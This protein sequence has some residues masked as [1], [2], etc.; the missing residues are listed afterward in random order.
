MGTKKK[1]HLINEYNRLSRVLKT[2]TDKHKV[3][4]IQLK[5]IRI[6]GELNAEF[7]YIVEEENND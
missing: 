1:K 4:E 6:S 3:R 2:M 5:L 7:K